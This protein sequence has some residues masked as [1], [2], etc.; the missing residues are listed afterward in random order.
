MEIITMSVLS[1]PHTQLVR[2]QLFS[3]VVAS[4]DA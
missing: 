4:S 1:Y 2:S 3:V